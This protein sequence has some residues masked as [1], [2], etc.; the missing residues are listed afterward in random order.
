MSCQAKLEPDSKTSD[1]GAGI[2]LMFVIQKS[3]QVS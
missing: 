3:L 1:F 2:S